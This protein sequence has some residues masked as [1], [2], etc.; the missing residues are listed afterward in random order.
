MAV[1]SA[2]GQCGLPAMAVVVRAGA[3]GKP[4]GSSGSGYASDNDDDDI[5]EAAIW[6]AIRKQE[7]EAA[8][9][10]SKP[11]PEEVRHAC[12]PCLCSPASPTYYHLHVYGS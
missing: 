5:D 7:Q 9:A 11:K 1:V 3:S 12:L 2:R 6:E 10:A 4:A 8:A